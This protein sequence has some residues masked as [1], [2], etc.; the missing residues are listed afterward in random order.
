MKN[1][2]NSFYERSEIRRNKLN[3]KDEFYDELCRFIENFDLKNKKILEIGS[4]MYQDIVKSYVGLDIA[5]SLKKYYHKPYH[6]IKKNKPYPFPDDYFDAIFTRAAFEHIP[7]INFAL[8]EMLRVLKKGG[9]ILFHMAW[10][11]RPWAPE[12][13]SIRSFDELSWKQKFIKVSIPFRENLVMRFFNIFRKRFLY[14][15]LFLINKNNF[16]NE[17]KYKKQKPNYKTKWC[18]DS[19]ACNSVDPFCM[20]LYFLANNCKVVGYNSLIKSLCVKYETLTIKNEI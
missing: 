15:L 12:G 8:K 11:V 16:R 7:N 19:D 17:L 5:K 13:I 2:Y 10:W 14:L 4:G 9:Y 3:K 1:N 18:A 6:I 20:I